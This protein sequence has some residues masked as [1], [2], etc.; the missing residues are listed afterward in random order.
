MRRLLK[1]AG[2]AAFLLAGTAAAA[3]PWPA[4]E[5]LLEEARREIGAPGIAAA[6][7]HDGRIVAEISAGERALGSGIPVRPS[8]QFHIGSIT[9]PLTA[10]LAARLVERGMISWNDTIEA[11]L[12]PSIGIGEAYRRVTLRELLSHRAGLSPSAHPGEAARLR[13][14]GRSGDQHLA[15]AELMLSLAPVREPGRDY[16]YS[17]FSYVVAAAMLEQATGRDYQD[18][19]RE[20]V[21]APLGLASA[22]FGAPGSGAAL[23]APRG[24]FF[25]G[26]RLS[27]PVPPDSPYAD[28]LPFLRPAGGLHMSMADLARF[29]G[30][31][32]LGGRGRGLLLSRAGYRLLRQPLSDR[33]ATGWGIG[34]GGELH[35]DGTNRRWFALLR[36]L[37]SER[38]AIAIAANAAG[39]EERTRRLVWA[40]G[41]RLAD[42][43]R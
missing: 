37:P 13:A 25:D 35:H 41:E 26:R 40:L 18:L 11:R 15:V 21:L 27:A 34:D 43:Y 6:I 1:I 4:G 32:I 8:D 22:G 10:T 12:G 33:Y 14:V 38:L 29:G 16:L 39:D 23:D 2:A 36:V 5:A 31:Q 17:N 20:E 3:Q 7:W 24:H 30:D 28:N 42:A 19:L 9:K